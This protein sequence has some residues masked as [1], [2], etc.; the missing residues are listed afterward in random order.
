M[1]NVFGIIFANYTAEGFGALLSQ[2]TIA[3]LP[4]GGRYRLIDFPLSNMINSGITT[5]GV[6]MPSSYRS[7]IDHIGSG[8]E[9]NLDRKI[10]GLFI[11]PGTIYGGHNTQESIMLSDLLTNS[12]YIQRRESETYALIASSN[13]VYNMDY[14][15]M[16]EQH[17]ESG[18]T[19]TFAFYRDKAGNPRKLETLIVNR[20]ELMTL[21]NDFAS[22]SHLD[23]ARLLQKEIPGS[24]IGRYEFSGYVKNVDSVQDYLEASFDLLDPAIQDAVFRGPRTIYTKTQDEAP[25]FYGDDAKVDNSLISAGCEI[26][27]TVENCI[28]FRNVK[29]AKD[30]VLKNCIV[31]QHTTIGAGA[32][33]ENMI[34]DKYITV[35]EGVKITGN[36]EKPMIIR[37]NAVL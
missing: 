18:K 7:L 35:N 32:N 14:R 15:P 26:D 17:I 24:D 10:G 37:K 6:I 5:V 25:T 34:M 31:M 4:Y 19:V 9:W 8:K 28:L 29:V 23:L 13:K 33:L 21:V 20:A 12:R 11:L 27:G 1:K 3:S 2:R 22:Y 16:V 36:P 30:A